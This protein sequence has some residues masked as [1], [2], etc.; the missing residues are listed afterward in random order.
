M[1]TIIVIAKE[2]I[3]GKVK[4]RLHPPLSYEQAAELAAA[5]LAQTLA[6][7]AAVPATRRILCFDGNRLPPGS[8]PFEVIPQVSG[9]LSVRLAS[10]FDECSGPTVMIGMDTPQVTAAN[11]APVFGEWPADV[12]A[13][14]GFANDGGYWVLALK[15][16]DGSLIRG[17]EMSLDDTGQQ[18][19]DRLSE[20]GLTVALLPELIDVDTIADARAVAALAPDSLFARTLTSFELQS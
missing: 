5:S 13:W 17:I 16:P 9:D 15:E 12:D 14:L 18:Q 2:T 1:T 4:T 6:V 8:E 19:Y 10:I 11:L 7:A 3:A 20:R